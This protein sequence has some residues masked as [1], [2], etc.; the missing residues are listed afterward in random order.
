MEPG[1]RI[2]SEWDLPSPLRHLIR[3]LSP[4]PFACHE[5]L[6]LVEMR[7]TLTPCSVDSGRSHSL[8]FPPN[9]G[10][11]TPWSSRS[12]LCCFH[13]YLIPD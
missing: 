3:E 10:P 6:R 1:T 7:P 2:F 11:Q 9:N 4:L 13:P 8:T 5:A 12:Y